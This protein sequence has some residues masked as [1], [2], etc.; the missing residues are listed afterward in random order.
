MLEKRVSVSLNI[1]ENRH[2]VTTTLWREKVVVSQGTT[3]K[4]EDRKEKF[5]KLFME[6]SLLIHAKE[7]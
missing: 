6:S 1:L 7:I 4:S 2:Q 3:E 5:T